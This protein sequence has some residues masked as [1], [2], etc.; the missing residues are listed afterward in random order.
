MALPRSV[1]SGAHTP[2]SAAWPVA[3]LCLSVS[4][5]SAVASGR[6]WMASNQS[7][8]IACIVWKYRW[9]TSLRSVSVSVSVFLSVLASV[10][11]PLCVSVCLRACLSAHLPRCVYICVWMCVPA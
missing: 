4:L 7:T 8:T 5:F 10:S 11:V 6:S 1:L 9:T 3:P 2:A